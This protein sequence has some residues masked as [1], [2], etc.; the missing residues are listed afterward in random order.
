MSATLQVGPDDIVVNAIRPLFKVRLRSRVRLDGYP[1]DMSADGQRFLVN[2]FVEEASLSS[3][4]TLVIN[5][6]ELVRP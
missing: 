4:L 6:P 2:A 3:P 1:Y 5:W